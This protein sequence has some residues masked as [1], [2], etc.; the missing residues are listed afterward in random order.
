MCGLYPCSCIDHPGCHVPDAGRSA[1]VGA[2][3]LQVVKR[4]ARTAGQLV[5][6]SGLRCGAGW[7]LPGC[8]ADPGGS[9]GGYPG[10]ECMAYVFAGALIILAAMFRMLGNLPGRCCWPAGG[11]GDDQD[12]RIAGDAG[13]AAVWGWLL[14]LSLGSLW[15][16]SGSL[17]SWLPPQV[18][19][20]LG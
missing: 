4:M 16:I 8:C 11:Q 6:L 15:G 19:S 5:T 7:L 9:F 17:S 20:L 3:G 13:K 10:L 14:R 1:R 18:H 2:A 12:S